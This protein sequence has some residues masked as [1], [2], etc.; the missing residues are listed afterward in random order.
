M[1]A[2]FGTDSHAGA[3]RCCSSR[4]VLS[5]NLPSLTACTC[6]LLSSWS[7]SR[8][9]EVAT[10]LYKCLCEARH[11]FQFFWC[12]LQTTQ[13]IFSCS[14]NCSQFHFS[15]RFLIV[16]GF[17]RDL[18]LE[19]LMCVLSLNVLLFKN[20]NKESKT[21]FFHRDTLSFVELTKTTSRLRI[22]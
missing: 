5:I 7:D 6:I 12:F 21:I 20:V 10:P 3:G 1:G 15:F 19:Q 2:F 8:Y 4:F 16:L 22:W 14:E 11:L 18:V 9:L 13:N 17:G